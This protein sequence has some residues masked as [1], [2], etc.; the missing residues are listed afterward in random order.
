MTVTTVR[1]IMCDGCGTW[2]EQ[3]GVAV[4]KPAAAA[5]AKLRKLGWAVGVSTGHWIGGRGLPGLDYC[6]DCAADRK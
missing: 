4:D 6:P 5:R 2:W 3:A 1:T